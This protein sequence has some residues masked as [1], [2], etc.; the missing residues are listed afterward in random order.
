MEITLT[1]LIA[2]GVIA[3]ALIMTFIFRVC[4]LNNKIKE[5]KERK[6]FC[7]DPGDG[8]NYVLEIKG[9]N[10]TVSVRTTQKAGKLKEY[11]EE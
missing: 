3:V 11:R 5:Y 10:G 1:V 4:A 2:S 8:K 7:E 9:R 6:R